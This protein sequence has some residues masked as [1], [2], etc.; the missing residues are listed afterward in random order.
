MNSPPITRLAI[1]P[2]IYR[3]G[4]VFRISISNGNNI[5]IIAVGRKDMLIRFFVDS[6]S[7]EEWVATLV[8]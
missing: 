7:V 8:E 4:W 1:F 6:R 2:I 3:D 5:L